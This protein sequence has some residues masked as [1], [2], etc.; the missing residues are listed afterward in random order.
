MIMG[1]GKTTVVAPL[2]ALMLGNHQTLVMQVS[3]SDAALHPTLHPS[4]HLSFHL[5]RHLFRH[6]SLHPSL[7]PYLQ[8]SMHSSLDQSLH[9]FLH[10]PFVYPSVQPSHLTTPP[11]CPPTFPRMQVVPPA[12]LEFS[13]SVMRQ[14][15][16][17]ILSKPV[18]TF[19]FDRFTA[20]SPEMLAKMVQ[21]R[22]LSAVMI[23]SP[24]SLKSFMLKFIEVVH[25]LEQVYTSILL[26][27][28][29]PSA[30][31]LHSSGAV[32]SPLLSPLPSFI[33]MRCHPMLIKLAR[34]SYTCR[35]QCTIPSYM[36]SPSYSH[37]PQTVEFG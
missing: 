32:L 11:F 1:A 15:F 10:P 6:L 9:H 12:L 37:L 36:I 16:S 29:S 30:S 3:P 23:T 19:S 34:N 7:H 4:L 17:S 26:L 18:Y 20:A 25:M 28:T 14:R 35:V 2:L 13:R 24:S 8:P 22:Q 5:S 33:G 31:L 21:A 27:P